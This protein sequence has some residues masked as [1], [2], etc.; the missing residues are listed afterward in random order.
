MN[1][2]EDVVRAADLPPED[3]AS[4]LDTL[5]ERLGLRIVREATP[6]YTS[7]EL[8]SIAGAGAGAGNA[9]EKNHG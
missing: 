5:I 7:Y 4:I 3:L 2:W 1:Q 9:S 6:D 8:Q